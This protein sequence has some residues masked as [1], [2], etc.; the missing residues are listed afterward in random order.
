MN[1]LQNINWNGRNY[2]L[3]KHV[4]N[5]RQALEDISDCSNHIT[6]VILDQSQRVEYLIDSITC[7]DSTLQVS[8]GLIRSNVN[9]MRE[10]F[11][12]AASTN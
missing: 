6:I 2:S 5:H 9:N 10:N 12:S 7:A 4:S 1:L 8:I 11:E 3:E